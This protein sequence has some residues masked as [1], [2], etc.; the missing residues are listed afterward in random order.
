M[1]DEAL[2]D[3]VARIKACTVCAGSLPLGPRPVLHVSPRARLLIA[4]QAPGT[5]VHETGISF[6]DASGD[7]LRSWLGMDRATFYDAEKV[8]LVPMGF[9]YPGRLPKGGDC[10]PRKECAPLWRDQVLANLP[11]VQLTL[12]VGSYA[13]NYVLG[14]GRVSERVAHFRDYLPQYFPLP[15]P[16]WRTGAWEKRNPWFGD[17]VLPALRQ[18]VTRILGK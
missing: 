14:P 7:R 5:K 2:S 8:A 18:E 6:N 1:N 10:P 15:H 13:Q 4:S 17:E 16:S 12:L 3:L 11:D 9:C